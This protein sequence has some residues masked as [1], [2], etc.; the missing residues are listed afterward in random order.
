MKT[1]FLIADGMGDWP[2]DALDGKTPLQAARTPHMDALARRGAMGLCRTVPEGMPPG[3]DVANMS[4][5]GFDPAHLHTGRG[6]IEAAAQGI[7][8]GPDDLIWRL[9]VVT[10]DGLHPGDHM[11]DYSSGHIATAESHKLIHRLQ[12]E[13]GDDRFRFV[14]GIQYRHLLI[15]K[16]GAK[17]PGATTDIRPPHDITDQP[18]DKDLESFAGYPELFELVRKAADILNGE[19]NPTKANSIWPWGQGR[20]LHLPDFAATFG[21]KGAVVTAVDLVRGLGKAAGMATPE[22]V[23]VTG[24]LD[25][26][27]EGKVEAALDFLTSGGDFVFVHLEAPDEC[28]HAGNIADKIESI[29][30]FDARVVAPIVAALGAEAR[31]LIAC[32]HLTPIAIRTHASDP[33]PFLYAGPDTLEEKTGV[34]FNEAA[35]TASGLVLETGHELL[36]WVLAR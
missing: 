6:P 15:E 35:C 16:N 36:P 4:L 1:L 2:I 10:L 26:N 22:V 27:Y 14:P 28:G 33:V 34:V 20:P 3:S 21:C 29:E 7:D 24:L 31:Y 25:T 9:N 30:R 18:V 5:L 23:D 19:D 13:L 32:D 17:G 8:A 11:R 12:A